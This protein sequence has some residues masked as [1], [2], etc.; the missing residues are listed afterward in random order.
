MFS[1]H[2]SRDFPEKGMAWGCVHYGC[3]RLPLELHHAERVGLGTAGSHPQTGIAADTGN[4]SQRSLWGP[5]LG[6]LS[7]LQLLSSPLLATVIKQLQQGFQSGWGT[8]NPPAP[9]WVSCAE[10]VWLPRDPSHGFSLSL[11]MEDVHWRGP[12]PFIYPFESFWRHLRSQVSPSV[13]CWPL[14]FLISVT[15]G[16]I[17]RRLSQPPYLGGFSV[18]LSPVQGVLGCP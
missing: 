4:R 7:S 2:F 6:P 18:S 15:D 3:G 17:D 12:P 14:L 9:P 5:G 16:I 13:D 8:H 10:G 1:V 11:K